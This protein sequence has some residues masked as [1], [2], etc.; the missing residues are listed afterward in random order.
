MSK[1]TK[2]KKLTRGAPRLGV[3]HHVLAVGHDY[4]SAF[5]R[6]RN[7]QPLPVNWMAWPSEQVG[8]WL[9][10]TRWQG[11]HA[12]GRIRATNVLAQDPNRSKV[13]LSIDYLLISTQP[14][15]LVTCQ[16]QKCGPRSHICPSITHHYPASWPSVSLQP[17][18]CTAQ[19]A[20]PLSGEHSARALFAPNYS[21]QHPPNSSSRAS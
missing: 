9:A 1:D 19:S 13:L 6:G 17:R 16:C 15:P 10:I 7:H 8:A 18:V 4:E 2:K 11:Y 20:L 21:K 5:G 3:V 14:Q 12:S